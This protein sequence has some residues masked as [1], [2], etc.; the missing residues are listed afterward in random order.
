ILMGSTAVVDQGMAAM[1]PSGNV[2]ALSYA[3]KLVL[4]MLSLSALALGT[5]TLPYLAQMVAAGD[6]AGCR[7]TLKQYSLLVAAASVPLALLVIAFSRPI[8][9]ILFQRGAFTPSDTELVSRVQICY[10]IQI[11]FYIW[12]ML[13]VRFISSVRRNDILMYASALALALDIT[14]N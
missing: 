11:P 13:F 9:R 2:A 5:A 4:G 7:H 6:W 10:A 12:S 3:N 1:L 8:V 14:L